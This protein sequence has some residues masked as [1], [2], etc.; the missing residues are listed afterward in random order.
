M[1]EY[2]AGG[3]AVTGLGYFVFRWIQGAAA[4]TVDVDDTD[5][6]DGA[7][8]T[9]GKL[10]RMTRKA[11]DL[12]DDERLRFECRSSEKSDWSAVKTDVDAA[13]ALAAG[14]HLRARADD[15][16]VMNLNGKSRGSATPAQP[17]PQSVKRTP[18]PPT[19]PRPGQRVQQ[20]QQ[21]R[22]KPVVEDPASEDEAE[23]NADWWPDWLPCPG[24]IVSARERWSVAKLPAFVYS[25]WM[26][27]CVLVLLLA[28]L[29]PILLPIVR[30]KLPQRPPAHVDSAQP[31]PIPFNLPSVTVPGWES[32]LLVVGVAAAVCIAGALYVIR[33]FIADLQVA[34]SVE[35]DDDEEDEADDTLSRLER[36]A[37]LACDL[38][39]GTNV[40]V[41]VRTGEVWTLL[42]TNKHATKVL[43]KY[44]KGAE[45]RARLPNGDYFMLSTA[46]PQPKAPE[47]SGKAQASR[48]F[49]SARCAAPAQPS[50]P[51]PAR[52]GKGHP[53]DDAEVS[54][55]DSYCDKCNSGLRCGAT[56][57]ACKVCSYAI[58]AQCFAS[59]T[60]QTVIVGDRKKDGRRVRFTHN[61]RFFGLLN[62]TDVLR[63]PSPEMKAAA[64][65]G[66][67]GEW[68]PDAS[69]GGTIAHYWLGLDTKPLPPLHR[70]SHL[71]WTL[72]VVRVP[73]QGGDRFV[74]VSEN[75]LLPADGDSRPIELPRD[76]DMA[77]QPAPTLEEHQAKQRPADDSDSSEGEIVW[78]GKRYS[79]KSAKGGAAAAR[80]AAMPAKD[81]PV[82]SATDD[83]D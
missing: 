14:W 50:A 82:R 61:G 29:V 26:I 15:G 67:W 19:R 12:T 20:P 11:Y 31:A 56:S 76:G 34:N 74:V 38:P 52:C 62:T 83:L 73:S 22:P 43:A 48:G 13:Q 24:F 5:D 28:I 2:A 4:A 30:S 3:A 10:E 60:H 32:G 7:D 36:A 58:C 57:H 70:R 42:Q 44:G 6:E 68:R 41:E 16:E 47:A 80:A 46:P 51:R 33:G 25:G 69:T 72:C 71:T 65:Q 63:W 64:G 40:D 18:A 81:E 66:A 27:P 54:D 53:L 17:K 59:K 55:D 78:V 21:Q 39:T 45:I 79:A 35:S 37:R 9:I 8:G 1:A 23:T 75:A 49:A 77:S